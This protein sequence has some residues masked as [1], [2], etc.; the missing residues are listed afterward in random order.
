[1][2]FSLTGKV[3]LITGGSRGIGRATALGFARA[4]AD[5]V[6]T[7]RKLPDL[8]EVAEEIRGLGSKSLA[9]ASHIGRLDDINA[10]VNKVNEEFG[11][12]DILINN[13][14]T[15]PAIAP[16]LDVDERLWDAI[17]N[18]N[19]KGLVFLSQAV[20]RVMKEHDGGKIINVASIDG[21]RPEPM[22]NG[23]YAISKAG[24]L[25]ATR[26]MAVEWAQYKIRVNAVAPGNVHTRLGDSRF[27][28]IAGYEEELV[29]RTPMKRIAEPDEMVGA[30]I[31]LASDAS[32][33]VTGQTIVVDG[34]TMVA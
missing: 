25:M 27:E 11:R 4:G 21:L 29:K 19:L 2:D 30:M 5:V 22:P 13:A 6:V 12:I 33:F 32:S 23:T 24:V 7:S 14:G 31:Y 10:L 16:I 8:E 9:V 18:L 1:M 28:V 3:A 20:A 26:V 34:G 15:S 17:M